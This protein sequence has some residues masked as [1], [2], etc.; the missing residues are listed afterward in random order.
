MGSPCSPALA[1]AICM[2]AEHHFLETPLRLRCSKAFDTSMTCCYLNLTTAC[3]DI[4]HIYPP[5]LELEEEDTKVGDK[6]LFRY[7]EAWSELQPSGASSIIHY[8]KNNH[9]VKLGKQPMKSVVH[10]SSHVPQTSKV[11]SCC[12]IVDL[13]LVSFHWKA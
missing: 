4:A 9:R 13:S 10:F 1:T 11:W 7:L 6:N 2:H 3:D 5:P 12:G 8:H